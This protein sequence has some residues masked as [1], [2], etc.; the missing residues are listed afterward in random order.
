V[1][2]ERSPAE[3]SLA[4]ADVADS[5]TRSGSLWLR[6]LALGV[7]AVAM[8]TLAVLM[9]VRGDRLQSALAVA[10]ASVCARRA[11]QAKHE[12]TR[13][14]A[15]AVRTMEEHRSEAGHPAPHSRDDSGPA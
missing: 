7:T 9:A 1:T 2:V 15:L 13:V 12:E 8:V 6:M 14:F 11:V 5:A 3:L 10:V 4:K